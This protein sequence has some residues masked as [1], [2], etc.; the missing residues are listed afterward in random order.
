[1]VEGLR[2]FA[3]YVPRSLVHRLMRQGSP[4]TIIS[5]DREVSVLFADIA[6]FTAHCRAPAG[7]GGGGLP[8]RHF[9]LVDGC[10]E[11]WEGTIDKYIGDAVMAFWGRR[12]SS[13]TTPRVPAGRR[14]G[15]R[16]PCTPTTRSGRAR[17][18]AGAGPHGHPQRSGR[19]RQIG[20]PSR[21]N[22]TVVG[23]VVN[24]AERLEELART[25]TGEGEDATI[26][27]SDDTASQVGA[28]FEFLP[29]GRRV[30]RGRAE[31]LEVLELQIR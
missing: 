21:V 7:V 20:A 24:V 8:Q 9:A 30:L 29:L 6:G 2:L 1:M 17:A 13:P 31:P 15:S 28:G 27:V 18:A 5:Q 23:D 14:L 3:T 19:G 11:A 12:G 22:Y 4:G 10:V 26:V 16:R 25:V